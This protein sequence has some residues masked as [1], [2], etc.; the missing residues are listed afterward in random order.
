MG[1]FE[2]LVL[3]AL[4]RQGEQ[5]YAVSIRRELAERSGSDVAMGAVYATLDRL[6]GKGMIA[7]REGAPGEGGRGRPRR[8]YDIL[9]AGIDALEQTRSVRASLWQGVDLEAEAGSR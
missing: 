5:A 3:L 9:A 7:P 2:E 1:A 4:I 8:Y 6:E